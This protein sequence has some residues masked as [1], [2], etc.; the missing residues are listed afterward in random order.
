LTSSEYA[1]EARGIAARSS[2]THDDIEAAIA[3]MREARGVR[4]LELIK[5]I[6]SW[7]R[8]PGPGPTV[9]DVLEARD[10]AR[11]ERDIALGVPP[12]VVAG[13]YPGLTSS[14]D[15]EDPNVVG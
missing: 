15:A 9:E 11:A 8:G 7:P 1:E 4:N 10:A 2:V 6:E 5:E 3:E 12:D 14:R 13:D